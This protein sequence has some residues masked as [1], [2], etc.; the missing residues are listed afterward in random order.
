MTVRLLSDYAGNPPGSLV[1]LSSAEEASLV[2]LK[3]ADTNLAGGVAPRSRLRRDSF[4]NRQLG[5]GNGSGGSFQTASGG[6]HEIINFPGIPGLL[7]LHTVC[8]GGAT[9]AARWV[10]TTADDLTAFDTLYFVVKIK[11]SSTAGNQVLGVFPASDSGLANRVALILDA[12]THVGGDTWIYGV[13]PKAAKNNAAG[14]LADGYFAAN[15]TINWAAI[16]TWQI[17]P[18]NPSTGAAVNGIAGNEY[19]I[20]APLIDAPRTP[21]IMIGWDKATSGHLDYLLPM[22]RAY[23]LKMTFYP[24]DYRIG[25]GGFLTYAQIDKL[26]DAG[27]GIAMHSYSKDADLRITNIANFPTAQSIADEILGCYA[28]WKAR[29][30]NVIEDHIC[31]AIGDPF[32]ANTSQ[33]DME[34]RVVAGLTLAGIKTVRTGG[35][36]YD[37]DRYNHRLPGM[38]EQMVNI[39]TFQLNGDSNNTDVQNFVKAARQRQCLVSM[40]GHGVSLTGA[41]GASSDVSKAQVDTWFGYI[42]DEVSKGVKNPLPHYS[43]LLAT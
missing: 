40:Y 38:V 30:W 5:W 34:G 37:L 24:Q 8:A 41:T 7:C 20:S 11:D 43:R 12:R 16:N 2:S 1:T 33:A 26:S 29:G 27:H 10:A 15:G 28:K 9:S 21:A 17:Q 35:N 23:G 14:T 4:N 19:W 13:R 25:T 31:M 32:D 36:T 18:V 6:T 22:A 42:A 39:N 3:M